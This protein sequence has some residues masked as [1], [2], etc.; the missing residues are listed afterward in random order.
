MTPAALTISS[1][2]SRAAVRSPSRV[3]IRFDGLELTYA[4]LERESARLANAL[5][6]P[7]GCRQGDRI[8]LLIG[9]RPE[10]LVGVLAVTRAGLVAVPL[11]AGSTARELTHLA[12]HSGM[13]LLLVSGE[14]GRRLGAPLEE[15]AEL[16][17]GVH[18]FEEPVGA[19]PT[20]AQLVAGVPPAPVDLAEEVAPFF[21]G[22]TSG[23]TG[24]PKAAVVG[25]RARTLL[26]LMYGQEYGGATRATRYT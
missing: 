21:F 13:R 2:F 17:I 10:F 15:L 9:N 7:G 16:G 3:A 14:P 26:A 11:P 4:E 6:G 18:G 20:V 19:F 8:G 23:T 22:Y 24:H 12:A 25:H 1:A 5:L